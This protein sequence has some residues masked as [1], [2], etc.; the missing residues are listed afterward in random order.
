MEHLAG[1]GFRGFKLSVVV[2]RQNVAQLDDFKAIAD[3]YGAV[4]AMNEDER[5]GAQARVP[6]RRF[7]R[8]EEVA[9]AVRFLAS[10]EASYI[11]GAVLKV[12]GGIL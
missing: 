7:G 11:T 1:A 8:P 5:K 6:M 3:R 2:T 4:S 9:A 10:A 12:D